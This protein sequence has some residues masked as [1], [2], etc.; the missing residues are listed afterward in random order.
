MQRIRAAIQG[1]VDVN[2]FLDQ[3]L[4]NICV[5]TGVLEWKCELPSQSQN[6]RSGKPYAA[7]S[8]RPV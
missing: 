6:V 5:S 2:A 8:I 7:R 4:T 1:H 3:G